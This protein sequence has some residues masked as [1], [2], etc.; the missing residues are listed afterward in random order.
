MFIF[1]SLPYPFR[2]TK[3]NKQT[4]NIPEGKPCELKCTKIF[5]DRLKELGLFSLEKRRLQGDLI[6]NCQCLK[7]S[8]RKEGD[9]LFSRVCCNRTKRN[10]F[11][12]K[13]DRFRQYIRKKSFTVMIVRHW[14][15]LPIDVVDALSLETFKVTVAGSGDGNKIYLSRPC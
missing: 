2:K 7:G 6:V 9:R 3:Q 12:I 8:Y 11:K 15:R 10:G 14:N 1:P 4:K 13:K 5:Q